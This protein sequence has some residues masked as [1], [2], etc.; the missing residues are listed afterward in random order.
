MSDWLLTMNRSAAVGSSAQNRANGKIPGTNSNWSGTATLR[1]GRPGEGERSF[2]YAPLSRGST[3]R[4][5]R[6]GSTKSPPR[7]PAD[8]NLVLNQDV[9]EGVT[10]E[11]AALVR[12]ELSFVSPNF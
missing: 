12:V 4:A 3:S 6:W 5:S 7:A 10:R 9:G 8:R 1:S 2:R 11:L